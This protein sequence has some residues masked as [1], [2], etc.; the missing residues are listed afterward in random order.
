MLTGYKVRIEINPR[1]ALKYNLPKYGQEEVTAPINWTPE[2][3]NEVE[4]TILEKHLIDEWKI[5]PP[6]LKTKGATWNDVLIAIKELA[7]AHAKAIRIERAQRAKKTRER[8]QRFA[9]LITRPVD[10][11]AKEWYHQQY[12]VRPEKGDPKEYIVFYQKVMAKVEE[13]K[14]QA[15]A[16][17]KEQMKANAAKRRRWISDYLPGHLERYDAGYLSDEELIKRV[18]EVICD[19]ILAY[20]GMEHFTRFRPLEEVQHDINCL[21]EC[22]FSVEGVKELLPEEFEALKI[23]RKATEDIENCSVT[24][25]RH[26]AKC[27]YCGREQTK[28]GFQVEFPWYGLKGKLEFQLA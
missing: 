7:E 20:P 18:Q 9:Q 5:D 14:A 25:R 26:V 19:N 22:I 2:G 24:P 16:R 21:D 12:V 17:E 10:E 8:R 27:P 3:L 13:L 6:T 4:K 15:K 23:L 1:T 11:V 28:L